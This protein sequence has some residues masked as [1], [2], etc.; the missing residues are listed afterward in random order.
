[1]R[2][3]QSLLEGMENVYEDLYN[4]HTRYVKKLSKYERK[5]K[6]F[7]ENHKNMVTIINNNSN[8]MSGIYKNAQLQKQY[9]MIR[10]IIIAIPAEVRAQYVR[11]ELLLVL[12]DES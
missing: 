3:I 5:N 11:P 7:D 12:G 2:N 4:I 9:D 1:M 10:K 8:A 6:D